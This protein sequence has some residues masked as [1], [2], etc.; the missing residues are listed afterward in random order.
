MTTG[1]QLPGVEELASAFR[2]FRY[3]VFRLETL[4]TYSDPVE[5][6][7]IAAFSR[8]DLQPPPDPAEVEWSA[9]LRAHH[10]AGRTQQRVHLVAEPIT[11]YLAY[12]LTWEYGPHSAAGED[13]R[14]IAVTDDWPDDVPR[15]DFTLFDSRLLFRLS[16]GPDGAWLGA[17]LVTD[18]AS[19]AAACLARDAALHQAMPWAA[20]MTRHPGLVARLSRRPDHVATQDHP[21]ARTPR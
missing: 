10:D 18:P 1:H 2:T 3:S 5:A 14:I 8:G 7:G 16:Y 19:V 13:I 21:A 20:Y 11:D 9:M 4:Q 15:A 12:E 6:G 17:E